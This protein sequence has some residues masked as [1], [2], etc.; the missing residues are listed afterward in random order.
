MHSHEIIRDIVPYDCTQNVG[1]II[2]G[3]VGPSGPPSFVDNKTESNG[4]HYEERCEKKLGKVET[5]TMA[6]QI[7]L[8]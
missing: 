3:R 6:L 2:T 1:T 7:L 4:L 5:Y 8:H